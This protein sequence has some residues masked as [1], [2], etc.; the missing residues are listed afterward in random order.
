MEF[1]VAVTST[2]GSEKTGGV[3]IFVAGFGMWTKGK[4]D[5][6]SSLISRIKF[7]IPIEWPLQVPKKKQ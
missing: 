6:S 5:T 7:S 2:E 1:D 4:S 3:G